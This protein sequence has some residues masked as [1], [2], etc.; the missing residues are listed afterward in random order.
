MYPDFQYLLQSL[1]NTPMPEW[2]GIFKTFGFLMALAFIAALFVITAEMKRKEKMGL[3]VPVEGDI[4]VIDPV[5][6]KKVMKKG[7][8]FPHER[9]SSIL[10]IAAIGG[11]AGAK[12]FNAFETWDYF[13]QDP[14]GS[15]F[16]RS[17]L[18]FYGGLITATVLLYF[19]ARKYKIPF[20]VLCDAA[21]PGLMLAYGIGRL[22]CHFSGD[23]DWGIFNSAYIADATGHL[24][25]AT[26]DQF[27]GV[28]QAF[29][30]WFMRYSDAKNMHDLASVPHAYVPAPSWLPD[31]F[32]GMNYM[33]NVNNEGIM[34][35]GCTGNYCTALPVSVFP[36]ALYEAIVCTGLFAFLWSIR[37]RFVQPLHLFGVYLILNGLERF[38]VEKIRVNY[39][40]DWGFLHPTQAEIISASLVLIGVVILLA[41]KRKPVNPVLAGQA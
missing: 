10:M 27:S 16:S 3:L 12:I 2:L 26:A 9:M 20:D 8:V 22:G 29:P 13:I 35:P 36:T 25:A 34:I 19:Y 39:K 40:Y 33:H 37:K 6:K 1:L 18:T 38:F 14:I 31:W 4:T 11:L 30:D 32:L 7:W 23:G 41:Y 5:T 28:V 17:G 24:K 21:A 15:L